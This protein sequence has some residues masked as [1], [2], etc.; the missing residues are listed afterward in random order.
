[1][2]MR[3][4]P[5]FTIDGE[6]HEPQEVYYIEKAN[7]KLYRVGFMWQVVELKNYDV[8]VFWDYGKLSMI[9][10]YCKYA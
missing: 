5:G 10:F 8:H 4:Q 6:R 3:G 9:F 1:M 2:L 7:V